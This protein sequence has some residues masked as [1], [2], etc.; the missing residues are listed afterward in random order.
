MEK[1]KKI[2][3]IV[4]IV[5]L[6]FFI[7]YSLKFI[8]D[9]FRNIE[10]EGCFLESI[11]N[12]NIKLCNEI[13]NTTK[14]TECINFFNFVKRNC[15]ERPLNQKYFCV[16]I[17]EKDPNYCYCI[18]EDWSRYDCLAYIKQDHKICYKI[19]DKYLKSICL[20]NFAI[21]FNKKEICDEIV[22]EDIKFSCN[23]I[24]TRDKSLCFDIGNE[25]EKSSCL[26]LIKEME[27]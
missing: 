13:A 12:D 10:Y 6:T 18:Q 25:E 23:A 11:Q 24:I 16:S 7:V 14:R 27:K 8:I 17:I 2:L 22:N 1:I 26:S 9:K 4:A 19:K 15:G 21:N 20:R 5:F 3:I